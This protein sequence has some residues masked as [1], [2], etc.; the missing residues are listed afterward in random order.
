MLT[1]YIKNPIIT[2]YVNI[3]LSS[4]D[5]NNILNQPSLKDFRLK[6]EISD[7]KSDG[8]IKAWLQLAICIADDMY[9]ENEANLTTLLKIHEEFP[10]IIFIHERI[11]IYYE[12]QLNYKKS[13]EWLRKGAN[14]GDP[15]SAYFIFHK[16]HLYKK[17]LSENEPMDSLKKAVELNHFMAIKTIETLSIINN[18]IIE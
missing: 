8:Y 7:K 4:H 10:E 12:K 6:H 9:M 18:K 14:E 2:N 17:E 16:S 11:S 1:D 15:W 5:L 3:G 13:L